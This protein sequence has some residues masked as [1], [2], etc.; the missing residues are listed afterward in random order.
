[1]KIYVSAISPS[2]SGDDAHVTGRGTV[3]SSVLS[4]FSLGIGVLLGYGMQTQGLMGTVLPPGI[5]GN[6]NKNS[7]AMVLVLLSER[8]IFLEQQIHEKMV[9]INL[10]NKKIKEINECKSGE[11]PEDIESLYNELLTLMDE[12]QDFSNKRNEY[13]KLY[14]E[15]LNKTITAEAALKRLQ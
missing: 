11:K 14:V 1:V 10:T 3:I 6:S 13:M 8:N 12:V 5:G 2:Y 9:L 15:V 4:N 7:P